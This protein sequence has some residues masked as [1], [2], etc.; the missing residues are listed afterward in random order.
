MKKNI[1]LSILLMTGVP[2]LAAAAVSLPRSI[3][4]ELRNPRGTPGLPADLTEITGAIVCASK[5]FALE[6]SQ[7]N[8]NINRA[9]LPVIA[10]ERCTVML[11]S[12]TLKVRGSTSLITYRASDK[13]LLLPLL[14]LSQRGGAQQ[15]L[16][17]PED[18]AVSIDL[19][20]TTP[21][22]PT[23]LWIAA[24]AAPGMRAIVGLDFSRTQ[25]I[26]NVMP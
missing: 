26:N 19:Q 12:M 7:F 22:F 16:L 6:A 20:S 11:S 25:A 13:P 3:E 18:S 9:T 10:D 1:V 14:S 8:F 2:M 15:P 23:Q 24:I 21:G 4:V 5:V 17:A